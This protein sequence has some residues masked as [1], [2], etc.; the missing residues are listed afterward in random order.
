MSNEEVDEVIKEVD[1]E[2]TGFM[3]FEPFIKEK[4]E[5]KAAV[6]KWTSIKMSLLICLNDSQVFL[7]ILFQSMFVLESKKFLYRNEVL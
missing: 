4:L 3:K 5:K 2:G 6:K 1:S 7:V